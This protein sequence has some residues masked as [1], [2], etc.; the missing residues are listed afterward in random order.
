MAH[1]DPNKCPCRNCEE[2]VMEQVAEFDGWWVLWCP[3]CGTY[4]K[5]CEGE[6]LGSE[7]WRI[8]RLN[9]LNM[10]GLGH[11]RRGIG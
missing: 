10:K 9:E 4:L 6:P 2:P 7:D 11:G 8:P 5:A 3:A 1:W